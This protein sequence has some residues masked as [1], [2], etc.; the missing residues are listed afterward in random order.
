MMLNL[1]HVKLMGKIEEYEKKKYL[2]VNDY[3]LDKVLNKIKIIGIEKFNNARI[4]IDSDY[5]L[6]DVI[7]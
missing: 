7:T 4:L 6:P 3:T 1:C 2:M 5:K